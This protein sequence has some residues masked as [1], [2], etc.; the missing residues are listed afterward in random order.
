MVLELE[1]TNEEL[2]IALMSELST[3]ENAV[4]E[5]RR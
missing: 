2:L 1:R 3:D 4:R 5:Y